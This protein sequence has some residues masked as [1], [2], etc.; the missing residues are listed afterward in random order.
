[1]MSEME[2]I[3]TES[4]DIFDLDACKDSVVSH[5]GIFVPRDVQVFFGTPIVPTHD[6]QI[7]AQRFAEL[8]Q[9]WLTD[10]AFT[11]SMTR[12]VES[13][14]YQEIIALGLAMETSVVRLILEDL[15]ASPKH[16]FTALYAITG[17]DPIPNAA[18]GNMKAMTAAWLDWGRTHGYIN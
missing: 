15:Q 9:E 13:N 10:I 4:R 18:A 5:R 7:V 12:I 8:T 11:S 6:A 2:A 16:W 3:P 1:M 17:D 14:P